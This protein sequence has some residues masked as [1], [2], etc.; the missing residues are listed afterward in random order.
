M[1]ITFWC[2]HCK[3][4]MKVPNEVA[5]KRGKCAHCGQLV[6]IPDS[7]D[8]TDTSTGLTGVRLTESG[9]VNTLAPATDQGAPELEHERLVTERA[10]LEVERAQLDLERAKLEREKAAVDARDEEDDADDRRARRVR[11]RLV[12]LETASQQTSRAIREGRLRETNRT[13]F[14]CGAILMVVVVLPALG[15]LLKACEQ[16]KREQDAYQ[17]W[18]DANARQGG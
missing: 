3:G 10:R 18:A 7:R 13:T 17:G 14:V 12:R 5:G 8:A 16:A 11:K 6:R 2:E 4:R 1:A 15:A 9:L